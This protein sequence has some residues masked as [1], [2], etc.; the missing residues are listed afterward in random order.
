MIGFLKVFGKGVLYTILFP[1]IVLIWVLFT[2]YCIFLF[3][4]SFIKSVILWIKGDSPFNDTKEDAEAKRILI[5]RQNQQNTSQ[6]N[7]QYKDALIA[8]LASA[9]AA[10][11]QANQQMNQKQEIPAVDVFPTAEIEQNEPTQLENYLGD[12]KEDNEQ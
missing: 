7:D 9:V 10:Q 1:F 12:E 8:T 2:V 5:D 4:Y 3:I 11:S 6:T